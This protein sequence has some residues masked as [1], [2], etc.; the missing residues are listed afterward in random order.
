MVYA[1]SLAGLLAWMAGSITRAPRQLVLPYPH[2]RHGALRF[3]LANDDASLALTR[4]LAAWCAQA[5]TLRPY[6][7]AI[8]A[9]LTAAMCLENFASQQVE[10]HNKPEVEM[11]YVLPASL[12][13]AFPLARPPSIEASCCC[14]I[15]QCCSVAFVDSVAL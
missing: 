5:N 3:D 6:L 2:I 15:D 13:L 8:R 4:S 7:T 9:T 14:P 11:G 12:R 1:R 10:R